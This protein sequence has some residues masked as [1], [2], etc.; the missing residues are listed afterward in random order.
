MHFNRQ[1][2]SGVFEQLSFTSEF[3]FFV[4]FLFLFF[5]LGGGGGVYIKLMCRWLQTG[6]S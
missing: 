6:L 2:F 3:V 5:F 4:V 1:T